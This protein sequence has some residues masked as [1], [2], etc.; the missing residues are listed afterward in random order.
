[1]RRVAQPLG[2]LGAL[3]HEERCRRRARGRALTRAISRTAARTSSKWCA[4]SRQATTSKLRVGE[5]QVL[6]AADDVGLHARR[7][8]ERD[9]LD[10]RLA[11]PPRD[12][13]AARRDV[14]RGPR[15][16][17]P[18]DEQVEIGALAVRLGLVAV[19]LA[20][21]RYQTSRHAASSTARRAASS[22]VGST[23]RFGG[24][25]LG[26]DPPALLGVRAVEAHDDRLLDRHLR[27]A[28][29]GSRARPRRSA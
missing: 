20:R 5:R 25:R 7:R 10:P 9:D 6:G 8:I 13:P 18:L 21:A 27:R 23:W 3:A 12:V 14:E 17:R 22:I 26:E 2:L 19:Q 11:Q 1:M 16:R 28:P 24:R 15:A 4:R 29:A